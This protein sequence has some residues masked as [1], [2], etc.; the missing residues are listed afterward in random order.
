MAGLERSAGDDFVGLGTETLKFL[1][2]LV[3]AEI[4]ETSHELVRAQQG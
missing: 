3:T 4:E 1:G 2:Y